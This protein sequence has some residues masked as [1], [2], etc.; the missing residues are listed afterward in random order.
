[1]SEPFL[2][3]VVGSLPKPAWLMASN[4]VEGTGEKQIHGK[5]T[6]WALEGDALDAPSMTRSGPASTSSA[7][8]RPGGSRGWPM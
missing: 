3:T 6:D 4:P 5:G 2:T 8:A 7:T 1:M